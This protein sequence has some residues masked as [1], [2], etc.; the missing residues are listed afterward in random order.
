MRQKKQR[1]AGAILDEKQHARRVRE[2]R[3]DE[4]PVSFGPADDFKIARDPNC[5]IL[6]AS[7]GGAKQQANH[8]S[9]AKSGEN[10]SHATKIVESKERNESKVM[11]AALTF[12]DVKEKERHGT[13]NAKGNRNTNTK[14]MYNSYGN[15][16]LRRSGPGGE[17]GRSVSST[18]EGDGVPVY[19]HMKIDDDGF[20]NEIDDDSLSS[21]DSEESVDAESSE[22][23][24]AGA[25]SSS[26]DD[27]DHSDS[28]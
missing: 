2:G 9:A 25:T 15:V 27:W 28:D 20:D 23:S 16:A 21:F 22:S 13:E 5:E 19:Y 14:N 11:L 3:G 17:G 1:R 12:E 10:D 18:P 6:D 24:D 26:E 7:T 8:I 4:V